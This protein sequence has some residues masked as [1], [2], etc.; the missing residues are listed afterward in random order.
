MSGESSN[1]K[2]SHKSSTSQL[3]NERHLSNT[4]KNTARHTIDDH[5]DPTQ[6]SQR[7]RQVSYRSKALGKRKR[8]HEDEADVDHP[9]KKPAAQDKECTVCL[10]L[11]TRNSFPIIQHAVGG[12]H[13]SDVCLSC[14]DQHIGSEIGSKS[15][16]GISCLQCSQRLVEEEVR[17]LTT[18]NTYTE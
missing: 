16:E 3:R 1:N 15:F 11:V 17:N 4:S 6:M 18:N 5:D 7:S 12:E 8:E 9:G 2:E 10:E 14:W 13:G